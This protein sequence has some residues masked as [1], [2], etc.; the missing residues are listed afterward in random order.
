M[1][2]LAPACR[3]GGTKVAKTCRVCMQVYKVAGLVRVPRLGDGDA[4]GAMLGWLG[5]A[6]AA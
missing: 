2:D 4:A 6:A 3:S 5:V 1:S